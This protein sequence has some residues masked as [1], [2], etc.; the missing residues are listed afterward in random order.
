MA[1]LFGI[2]MMELLYGKQ[3]TDY[4]RRRLLP[5]ILFGGF[6]LLGLVLPMFFSTV[7]QGFYYRFE[8]GWLVYGYTLLVRCCYGAFFP[9]LFSLISV[10]RPFCI[11]G[12][13]LR[14][15]LV[16]LGIVLLLLFF[17]YWVFTPLYHLTGYVS[18]QLFIRITYMMGMSQ[19]TTILA[20][21][22]F[23]L[24]LNKT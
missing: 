24:G 7:M 11:K 15:I 6:F 21:G 17:S 8:M 12:L 3:S 19:Y 9:F 20:G 1:D 13:A 18:Q 5:T 4:D 10:F 2:D 23:L 14:V 22:L 16:A